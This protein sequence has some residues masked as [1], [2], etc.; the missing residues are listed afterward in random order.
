MLTKQYFSLYSKEYQLVIGHVQPISRYTANISVLCTM[1]KYPKHHTIIPSASSGYFAVGM[2]F[3]SKTFSTSSNT[4]IVTTSCP[5]DSKA[6]NDFS[7]NVTSMPL[8]PTQVH[9]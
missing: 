5:L 2:T 6:K 8:E 1:A 9:T 4:E 3:R 7:M